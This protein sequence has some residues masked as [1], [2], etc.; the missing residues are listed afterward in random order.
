MNGKKYART[1]KQ[2]DAKAFFLQQKKRGGETER[3][4]KEQHLR[5]S[6]ETV[7]ELQAAEV[8]VPSLG[9]GAQAATPTPPEPCPHPLTSPG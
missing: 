4:N 1:Q 7:R 6:E 2:K 3:G 8:S 5:K 9:R